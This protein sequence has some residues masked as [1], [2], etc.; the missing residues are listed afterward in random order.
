MR[1]I[2]YEAPGRLVVK[3]VRRPQ[4]G[5]KDVL[6]RVRAAGICGNDLEMARGNRP[7]MTQPRIPGHEVA[8]EI[9]EIGTQVAGF[10]VGD[11]VV[12]EP[13]LSC[14]ECLTV[15]LEGIMSAR[16]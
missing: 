8:G 15:R 1:A 11:K 13:I 12:V 5:S 7:D 3:D 16:N 14:G 6:I 10:S 9:A 2:V 4:V